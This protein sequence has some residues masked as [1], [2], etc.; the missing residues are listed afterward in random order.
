MSN[1]QKKL[2]HVNATKLIETELKGIYGK[3]NKDIT[4]QEKEKYKTFFMV[5]LS[6][7][8]LEILL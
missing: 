2:D 7:T 1:I 6:F 5:I 3:K 8:L 4:K